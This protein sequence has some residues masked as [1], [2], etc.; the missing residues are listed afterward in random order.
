VDYQGRL[1]A[2][3]PTANRLIEVKA[4]GSVLV[5]SDE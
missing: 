4:D 1:T 3:L 5:G 2:H